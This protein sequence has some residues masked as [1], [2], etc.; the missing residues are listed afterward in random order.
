MDSDLEALDDVEDRYVKAFLRIETALSQTRPPLERSEQAWMRITGLKS[1]RSKDLCFAHLLKVGKLRKTANGGITSDIAEREWAWRDER[2][3]QNSKNR[4]ASDEDRRI[5]HGSVIQE[6]VEKTQCFQPPAVTSVGRSLPDLENRREEQ[7]REDSLP[8]S[9]QQ[10]LQAF[11][12]QAT[13]TRPEMEIDTESILRK[14]GNVRA[15]P[16]LCRL[17]SKANRGQ[18]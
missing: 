14:N 1:K 15:S 16:E 5:K 4:R 3:Q 18:G 2:S 17:E 6:P 9:P 8:P 10:S 11:K 7:M 13:H 12:Q